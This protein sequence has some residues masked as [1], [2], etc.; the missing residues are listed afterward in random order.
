[1]EMTVTEQE[2]RH[3]SFLPFFVSPLF[4]CR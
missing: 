2:L 4:A 3:R 1:M